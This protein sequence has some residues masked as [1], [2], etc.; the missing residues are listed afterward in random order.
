MTAKH[1]VT[2][3]HT[4][5][6]NHHQQAARFHREASKHFEIGKDYAHAAHQALIAHGHAVQ[7]IHSGNEARRYY[8]EHNGN[9]LPNS[10]QSVLRFPVK[11]PEVAATVHSGLS[12]AEHHEA[13]AVHHEQAAQH[14][15]R[16][17]KHHDENDDTLA[18]HEARIADDH[19]QR[20]VFH[21]DE[22]ARHHTEHYGKSGP[23]AEIL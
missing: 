19:A 6:A 17:V 13:A 2:D 16:A 1:G 3:H 23:T 12:G 5:A 20:S 22:A 7:A 14:H 8:A 18:V 4:S 10:L 11:S 9:A 15:E 21:G